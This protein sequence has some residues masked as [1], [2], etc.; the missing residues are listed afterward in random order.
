MKLL[1]LRVT[2]ILSFCGGPLH[3]SELLRVSLGQLPAFLVAFAPVALLLVG[4]LAFRDRPS[5]KMARLSIRGGLLGSALLVAEN[6]FAAWR[7]SRGEP[8]PHQGIITFGIFVGTVGCGLYARQ[9]LRW[10]RERLPET[11]A[12]SDR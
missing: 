5:E 2:A 12:R 9:A 7:L 8:H 4:A 10:L 11:P 1:L 3:L 6:A